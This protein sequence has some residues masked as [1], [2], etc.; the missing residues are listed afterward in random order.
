MGLPD[1]GLGGHSHEES[2][3]RRGHEEELA[4]PYRGHR[5]VLGP[6]GQGP[7]DGA[8]S[9]A[10]S[11]GHELSH[12]E[13]ATVGDDAGATI[14]LDG[15]QGHEGLPEVELA[16]EQMALGERLQVALRYWLT[17]A[18]ATIRARVTSPGSLY[19]TKPES[20]AEHD[21]R[22]ARHEWVPEGYEGKWLA[23]LGVA[24]HQSVG[25][26]GKITGY[27]WAWL[28]DTPLAFFPTAVILF[29]IVILIRF[30]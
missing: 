27:A 10:T 3:P 30:A 7:Q 24:Y 1:V 28:L 22:I 26:F 23:H 25:K 5:V 12:A 2:H 18:W 17:Q 20:L 21:E 19:H 14:R 6:Q 8:T 4:P 13:G 29:V 15:G 9:G 11:G 16:G